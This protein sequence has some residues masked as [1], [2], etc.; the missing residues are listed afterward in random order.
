VISFLATKDIHTGVK[1]IALGLGLNAGA[2]ALILGVGFGLAAGGEGAAGKLD[3]VSATALC[4]AGLNGGIGGMFRSAKRGAFSID[5]DAGTLGVAALDDG[6]A[7]AEAGDVSE[8]V[9]ETGPRV[10]E[11]SRGPNIGA[12][13]SGMGVLSCQE[14]SSTSHTRQSISK[15]DFGRQTTTNLE[16]LA[17]ADEIRDL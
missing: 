1:A 15:K 2:A 4:F 5:E 16:I 3:L 13:S 7:P 9:R 14:Q 8:L 10:L 11:G 6:F 17:E 12:R